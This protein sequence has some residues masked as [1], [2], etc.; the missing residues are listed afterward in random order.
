[1][2]AVVTDRLRAAIQTGEYLPGAWL[3][4]QQIAE[5]FGVS[6]MPVREALKTLSAEGLIEHVPYRGAR[7]IALD[8]ND[9]DDLYALRALLEG[10]AVASA[11]PTLSATALGDLRRLTDD[12]AAHL[13]Y[14]ALATYRDLN[15]QFHQAIYRRCGRN[16]LIRTLDR[17]W[18]SS[19]TMLWG[20]YA[21]TR[22]ASV[23]ARDAVDLSEH[24]AILAALEAG[25]AA[26]ATL[27]MENHILAAGRHFAA[28]IGALN[29]S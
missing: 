1:L 19:P 27:R 3:R 5:R 26:T 28:A 2:R 8:L 11:V 22:D 15:R 23:P 12:M 14:A 29:S 21:P 18:S 17:L 16:Y 10:R 24:R 7:V 6:Q 20:H 9:I 13:D 25:D 4:Q